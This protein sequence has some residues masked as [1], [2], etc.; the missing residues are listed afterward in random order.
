MASLKRKTLI[1]REEEIILKKISPEESGGKTKENRRRKKIS[2]KE[3]SG[4]TAKA[5]LS[6]CVPQLELSGKWLKEHCGEEVFEV[7]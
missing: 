4:K 2:P 5:L 3:S 7:H 6:C 1:N